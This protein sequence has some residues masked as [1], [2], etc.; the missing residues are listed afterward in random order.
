M[1]KYFNDDDEESIPS[2]ATSKTTTVSVVEA[3]AL[4]NFCVRLTS[5]IICL[6]LTFGL[7]RLFEKSY[8]DLVW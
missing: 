6:C 5:I 8:L 3:S 2:V 7:A 1:I 4:T